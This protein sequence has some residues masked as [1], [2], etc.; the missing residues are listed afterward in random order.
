MGIGSIQN[1]NTNFTGLIMPKKVILGRHRFDEVR[2]NKQDILQNSA[3][4]DCA[5][6]FD[7]VIKKGKIIG[8][9][10]Y[11]A[12]ETRNIILSGGA[13]GTLMGIGTAAL[14]RGISIA[15]LSTIGSTAMLGAILGT[16][17]TVGCFEIFK[18]LDI[19]PNRYD[20]TLQAGKNYNKFSDKFEGKSSRIRRFAHYSDLQNISHLS[21]EIEN[22]NK[23]KYSQLIDDSDM[24]SFA[25]I[26][27]FIEETSGNKKI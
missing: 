8:N 9:R 24:E 10:D 7:V 18:G 12:K 4:R 20:Y 2:L 14:L 13:F 27:E 25:A 15:T 26:R 23:K 16:I 5:D 3:I 22:L 19:R 6:R 17:I 21:A 1:N 11:T